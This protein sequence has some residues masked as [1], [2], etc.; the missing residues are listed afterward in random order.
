MSLQSMTGHNLNLH[1]IKIF[2][3]YLAVRGH[4]NM[5]DSRGHHGTHLTMPGWGT[6]ATFSTFHIQY[7]EIKK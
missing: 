4:Q 3:V 2:R 5:R 6:A 7:L 1:L